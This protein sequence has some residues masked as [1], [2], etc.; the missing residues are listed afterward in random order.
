ML[1]VPIVGIVTILALVV[2]V[3]D[4]TD[5]QCGS[6]IEPL[7]GW[8]DECT[9]RFRAAIGIAIVSGALTVAL[10]IA[11]VRLRPRRRGDK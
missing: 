11:I 5:D 2:N 4:T 10:L 9:A 7:Y 3:G 8:Y 6:L 1:F